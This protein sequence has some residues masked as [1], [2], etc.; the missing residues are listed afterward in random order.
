MNL[1]DLLGRVLE[2]NVTP[3]SHD[4][5]RNAMGAGAGQAGGGA[6]GGLLDQLKGL[7][8]Q[9]M[10]ERLKG[11]GGDMLARTKEGVQGGDPLAIGGLAALAGAI[12][13][14]G[15]GALGG[16]VGAGALAVLAKIAYD[17][18]QKGK[19]G[20]GELPLGLREPQTPD[21]AATLENRAGL[22]LQA[23]VTA[24]KADGDID[25]REMDKISAKLEETGAD[26]SMIDL[27][28]QRMQGPADLAGLIS[29]VP[30][31]E[32]GLQVYAATL[33]AIEVDTDTERRYLRDLAT[34]LKLDPAAVA[35]VHRMLGV[36]A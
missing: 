30:D 9:D 12:L 17:A 1:Q 7:D 31:D 25:K 13:G 33:L 5:L 14:G 36:P 23:M 19:S 8:G 29:A 16:A 20:Q 32:T 15:R 28:H 35:S 4:R 11:A 22:I 21:E 6:L 24:A 3:S 27:V 18:M 2:A 10:V 26:K 34:G